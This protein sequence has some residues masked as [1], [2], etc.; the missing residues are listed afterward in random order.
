[1]RDNP[2]FEA[3]FNFYKFVNFF[4]MKHV[5]LLRSATVGLFLVVLIGSESCNKPER[6]ASDQRSHYKIVYEDILQPS[7]HLSELFNTYEMVVLDDAEGKAM[8]GDITKVLEANGR[9]VVFDKETANS[10]F[11]YDRQGNFIFKTDKGEGP[12]QTLLIEDFCVDEGNNQLVVLDNGAMSIKFYDLEN[13][14]FVKSTKLKDYHDGIA[15]VDGKVWLKNSV[16]VAQSKYDKAKIISLKDYDNEESLSI[17]NLPLLAED[18]EQYAR[19][20]SGDIAF[21]KT[22]SQTFYAEGYGHNIYSLSNED[23]SV[24]NAIEI[25]FGKDGFHNYSDQIESEGDLSRIF[26]KHSTKYIMG[27]GNAGNSKKIIY[28]ISNGGTVNYFFASTD[29]SDIAAYEDINNDLFVTPV[30]PFIGSSDKAVYMVYR[31]EF[32]EYFD[33]QGMLNEEFKKALGTDFDGS[34]SNP[35]LVRLSD[36]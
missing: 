9:T 31:P 34:T 1:M 19:Y 8:F 28:T 27:M 29:L 21:L 24:V 20:V 17:N 30:M 13:G 12:T 2:I 35:V 11:V 32:L 15:C 14:T 18:G 26:E 3:D 33:S 25:D 10:I 6:S 22:G 7:V 16:D 36:Q 4:I 23:G 5:N